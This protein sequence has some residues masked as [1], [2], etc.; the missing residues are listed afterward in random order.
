[1]SHIS[2]STLMVSLT[3]ETRDSQ[4][5]QNKNL[6]PSDAQIGLFCLVLHHPEDFFKAA[7]TLK[8]NR[9]CSK[10]DIGCSENFYIFQLLVFTKQ[11]TK[12]TIYR[13]SFAGQDTNQR[14]IMIGHEFVWIFTRSHC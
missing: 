13:A 14:I 9:E 6:H 5:H 12:S 3:N 8:Q 7:V 10:N 11:N 4:Q 1:M 2:I